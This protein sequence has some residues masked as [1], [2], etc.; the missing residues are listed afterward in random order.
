MIYL[1]YGGWNEWKRS[2]VIEV[3]ELIGIIVGWMKVEYYKSINLD[4]KNQYCM[5]LSFIID[6]LIAYDGTTPRSIE[7]SSNCFVWY[8]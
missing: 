5:P 7:K 2:N 3:L 1:L 8:D 4:M 6:K